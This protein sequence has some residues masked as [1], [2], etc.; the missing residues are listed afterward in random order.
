M[1][2]DFVKDCFAVFGLVIGVVIIGFAWSL[3]I[4]LP[5]MWIWNYAVVSAIEIARPI[6]YW[7]AFWLAFFLSMFVKSSSSS[8]SEK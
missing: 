5:F 3:A 8:T 7:P 2:T 1:K 4:A 6:T